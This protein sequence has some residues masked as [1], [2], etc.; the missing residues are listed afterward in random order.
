MKFQPQ[1]PITV[2]LAQRSTKPLTHML[3][4]LCLIAQPRMSFRNY[5]YRMRVLL[6]RKNHPINTPFFQHPSRP[7]Q[8][9]IQ[10][11]IKWI[12]DLF[13][14]GKVVGA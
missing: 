13:P 8:G 3:A 12:P 10:P 7:A 11:P 5:S 4:T 1:C 9:P 14:G 2:S 6:F